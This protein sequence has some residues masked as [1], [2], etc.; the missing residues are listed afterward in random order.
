MKPY[1]IITILGSAVALAM[2]IFWVIYE[3]GK[4]KPRAMEVIYACF[5]IVMIAFGIYALFM[6]EILQEAF[7]EEHFLVGAWIVISIGIIILIQ[8]VIKKIVLKK[9]RKRRGRGTILS[10]EEEV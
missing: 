4:L 9:I 10:K 6:E 8:S 5:G 2:I 7:P 1:S 3:K